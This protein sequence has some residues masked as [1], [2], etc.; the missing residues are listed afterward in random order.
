MTHRFLNPDSP[1]NDSPIGE[2]RLR[3]DAF[4]Y[5]G[6]HCDCCGQRVKYQDRRFRAVWAIFLRECYRKFGRDPFKTTTPEFRDEL[7]RANDWTFLA[8]FGLMVNCTDGETGR[9]VRGWW[10]ITDRG[11]QFLQNNFAIPDMVQ[12]FDD[13]V[14]GQ[15]PT[16]VT[17]AQA[18]EMAGEFDESEPFQPATRPPAIIA[19]IIAP[20]SAAFDIPDFSR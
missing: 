4:K 2:E 11:E 10:R 1:D 7:P 3:L 17:F 15:S 6:T 16:F 5:D 18:V 20:N 19:P 14:V 8:D 13:K 9:R 12:I